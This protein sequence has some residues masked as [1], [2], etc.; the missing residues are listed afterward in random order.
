MTKNDIHLKSIAGMK[1]GNV[2]MRD[3]S[4][5]ILGEISNI[6]N[7]GKGVSEVKEPQILKIIKK[8]IESNNE[9]LKH[10]ANDRLK[11]ENEF[12]AT[13]LPKELSLDEL[14]GH[15]Q[16]QSSPELLMIRDAANEGIAYG[17][18]AKYMKDAKLAASSD[19]IRTF[20]QHI[21]VERSDI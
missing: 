16:F 1:S 13:L 6:E 3:V 5:V 14:R 11:A 9:N 2:I 18:A 20:V 8:L 19:T 15:F 4:R 21:R 10:R 17:I 12:L 7:S